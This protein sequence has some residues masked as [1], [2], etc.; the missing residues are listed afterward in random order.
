M[1]A[2][3]NIVFLLVSYLASVAQG[4][5]IPGGYERCMFYYAYLLDC[6]I[7]DG[8]P[9]TIGTG[10]AKVLGTGGTPCSMNQFLEFIMD[11]SKPANV[12]SGKYPEIPPLEDT[13]KKVV[14]GDFAGPVT[15][16]R[17]H[18]DGGKS[19]DY[20]KL[21]AKVTDFIAQK[22][23][24]ADED[25]RKEAK[26]SVLRIFT[27]RVEATSRTFFENNSDIEPKYQKKSRG[28]IEYQTI[29]PQ[30]TLRANPNLT[31][32]QLK[33]RFDENAKGGHSN[34]VRALDASLQVIEYCD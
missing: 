30:E 12:F 28:G 5:S 24:K 19:K 34:N 9:T 17:V 10:C 14:D 1:F 11:P 3:I 6:K 22:L 25:L 31:R 2:F 23:P 29:D 4:Y 32:A 21:L 18:T 8:K 7:N 27:S 33:E 13:A 16:G 15:P 26:N 20:D